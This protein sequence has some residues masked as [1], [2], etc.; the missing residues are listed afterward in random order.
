MASLNEY[1]L[2]KQKCLSYFNILQSEV[3]NGFKV[4]RETDKER[5][6][7]YL[8]MIESICNI[9]DTSDIVELI[10][11]T[12]FNSTIFNDKSNDCGVDAIQ[13][14]YENNK[15]N[16]F[17]F[18]YR[19]NFNADKS[20]GLN[21]PF[22]STKFTGA[23]INNNYTHLEGKLKEYAKTILEC[24]NT[25]DIWNMNLYVISNENYSLDTKN[26]DIKQLEEIHDLQV[27]SIALPEITKYM[28]IRPE[29]INAS[30]VF[31]NDS[32]MSYSESVLASSKSF[33][34][35]ITV[36]ELIR[37]TCNDVELREKYNI[38]ELNPLSSVNMDYSLLFDNVRGFLGETKYNINIIDTLKNEATKFFMYNNGLTIT[39]ENIE[40]T[41]INGKTKMKLV[42]K[43]FQVVNGGQT[44]RTIHNFNSMS[45]DNL[46]KYLTNCE[47]L[48]RV[49]KTSSDNT[50]TNKIAEY[51]NSQNSISM[52]DLKALSYE[53][54]LIENI[55]NENNI[56]YARKNGDVGISKEKTY[57]HK[58][59][60]EKFAQIIFSI[61][62][63]P[64]KASNQKKKIFDKYYNATFKNENFD[65]SRSADIVKRYYNVKSIYEGLKVKYK[66]DDQKIFYILWMDN[67]LDSKTEVEIEIFEETI[68]KFRKDDK[69]SDA[70]KLIQGQFKEL[71]DKEIDC[72]RKLHPDKFLNSFSL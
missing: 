26:P 5:F 8:Y 10:T 22:I 66:S 51:T 18:K 44:L 2:L 7:F 64:E 68:K 9:K 30:I 6:G 32:I 14:D 37:I 56:I 46:N 3:N 67:F 17:N 52:T 55:L 71:L 42:I 61:Q 27:I 59:S 21:D 25:N 69:I 15:I 38:E 11:D 57:I 24:L 41:E 13:I 29:P 34:V 58:I 45:S 23:I 35:R 60:M 1:K 36:P 39:A 70:R 20:Q 62:G 16:L 40:A 4:K 72:Y 47:I 50:L 33:I 12:D 65:I 31:N 49:F 54:I 19:E 48:I 53:Q 43:N 28:S 63:F